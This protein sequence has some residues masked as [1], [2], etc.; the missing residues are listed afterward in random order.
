MTSNGF[1]PTTSQYQTNTA[2]A[3]Q[4]EVTALR[5]NYVR[6]DALLRK[7]TNLSGDMI[8]QYRS[9]QCVLVNTLECFLSEMDNLNNKTAQCP[10]QLKTMLLKHV[11][12]MKQVNQAANSM[13][14]VYQA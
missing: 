5:S 10:R 4:K 2:F 12:T 14:Q 8:A 6:I 1:T 3:W 13:T 11:V 9:L 7:Q